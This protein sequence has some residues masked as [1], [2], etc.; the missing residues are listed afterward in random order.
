MVQLLS[1]LEEAERDRCLSMGEGDV[2]PSLVDPDLLHD[3]P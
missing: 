3:P 1:T 2:K